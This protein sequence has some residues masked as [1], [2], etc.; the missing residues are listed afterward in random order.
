MNDWRFE[1][2]MVVLAKLQAI[3]ARGGNEVDIARDLGITPRKAFILGNRAC[4]LPHETRWHLLKSDP[5][6]GTYS[7]A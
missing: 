2:D 1:E 5:Q 6:S 3:M 7:S 4:E